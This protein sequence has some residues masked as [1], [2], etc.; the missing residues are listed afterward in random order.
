MN[1]KATYKKKIKLDTVT[2]RNLV[3]PNTVSKKALKMRKFVYWKVK[4]QPWKVKYQP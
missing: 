3:L 4:Y 1:I 2:S